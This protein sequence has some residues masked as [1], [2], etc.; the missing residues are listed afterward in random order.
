MIRTIENNL[1][2]QVQYIII[3]EDST[4]WVIDWVWRWFNLKFPLNTNLDLILTC[5]GWNKGLVAIQEPSILQ[6]LTPKPALLR[7]GN[8]GHG[9]ACF[10]AGMHRRLCP[11]PWLPS[12]CKWDELPGTKPFHHWFCECFRWVEF[13]FQTPH[14]LGDRAQTF[15]SLA[16]CRQPANWRKSWETRQFSEGKCMML[17]WIWNLWLMLSTIS[18]TGS[19]NLM[20]LGFWPCTHNCTN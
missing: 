3:S 6:L 9:T 12:R 4:Q 17:C 11:E 5:W 2:R 7:L 14:C 15:R 1:S 8:D 19:R 13:C 18:S 10:V 20:S 16:D